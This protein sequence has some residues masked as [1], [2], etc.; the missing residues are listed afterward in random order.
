MSVLLVYA[1]FVLA[2]IAAAAAGIRT[3]LAH[4]QLASLRH[5]ADRELRRQRGTHLRS[6]LADWRGDEL[7]ARGR[8][9]NRARS[10]RHTVRDLSPARLPGPSPLHRVAV[11]P[12]ADLLLQLADRVAALERP[13]SPYGMLLV[14]DLLT[15]PG[16]PLYAPERAAEIRSSIQACLDALEGTPP[17]A[18]L[19]IA[20]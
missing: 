20:S 4:E 17:M 10:L 16:S 14:D 6:T 9:I 18:D 2:T 11:R 7:T 3:F 12:H 15:L 8:R 19:R 13:V 1:G 5:R